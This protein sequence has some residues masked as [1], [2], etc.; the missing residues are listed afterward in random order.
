MTQAEEIFERI[1]VALERQAAAQEEIAIY[2]DGLTDSPDLESALFLNLRTDEEEAQ[3][4][5]EDED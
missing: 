2:L 5:A 3:P 1:A 4:D